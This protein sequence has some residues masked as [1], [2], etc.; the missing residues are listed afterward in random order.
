[1]SSSRHGWAT[2]GGV[3]EFT[4]ASRMR[5]RSR[6]IDLRVFQAV[7]RASEEGRREGREQA[8]TEA[9]RANAARRRKARLVLG[10]SVITALLLGFTA[11][12]LAG[13]LAPRPRPLS[14]ASGA[15]R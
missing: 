15:Q 5:C 10:F 4:P 9:A 3:A 13:A 11:G 14:E 1:M 8:L 2:G 12:V 6:E 7:I